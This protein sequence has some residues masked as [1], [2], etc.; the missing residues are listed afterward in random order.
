M[1]ADSHT[2]ELDPGPQ[3]LAALEGRLRRDLELLVE[4]A[5]VWTPGSKRQPDIDTYD[6]VIVGAGMAGLTAAFALM[7]IGIRNIMLF[8]KA[9]KGQEGP[10]VTFARMETLRSPKGSR[11][12]CSLRITTTTISAGSITTHP[13]CRA[14]SGSAANRQWAQPPIWRF[15]DCDV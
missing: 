5:Q 4:P 9:D 3:S 2:L 6:V 7:R 1:T 8:D 14:T 10:W 15:V 11:G 13:S 12:R